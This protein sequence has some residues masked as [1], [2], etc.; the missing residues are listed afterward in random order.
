[1]KFLI[2]LNEKC[3]FRIISTKTAEISDHNFGNFRPAFRFKPNT[4]V[5][6]NRVYCFL[7]SDNASNKNKKLN[8]YATIPLF[9]TEVNFGLGEKEYKFNVVIDNDFQV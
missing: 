7:F 3:I 2:L 9:L 1:M 8:E 6:I 4:L 5:G